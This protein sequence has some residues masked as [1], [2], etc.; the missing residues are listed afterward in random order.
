MRKSLLSAVWYCKP[1]FYLQLPYSLTPFKLFIS[2]YKL[3][4]LILP[5]ISTV[6]A[7][8]MFLLDTALFG[9]EANP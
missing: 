4:E 1:K 3:S 2:R 7:L 8:N 6:Q 5:L 9:E